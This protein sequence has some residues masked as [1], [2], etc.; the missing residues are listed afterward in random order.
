MLRGFSY[1]AAQAEG[2]GGCHPA[3]DGREHGSQFA[4]APG[5]LVVLRPLLTR[6]SFQRLGM[7]PKVRLGGGKVASGHGSL[8]PIS[9]AMQKKEAFV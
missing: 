5:L 6:P 8:S 3:A 2:C 1:Q 9:D 4:L 7:E